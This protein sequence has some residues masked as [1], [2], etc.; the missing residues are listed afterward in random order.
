MNVEEFPWW[1]KEQRQ[2]A[3]EVEEFSREVAP[4]VEEADWRAKLGILDGSLPWDPIPQELKKRMVEKGYFGAMIPKEYGG[5]GLGVTGSCI[6]AEGLGPA[7]GS[8]VSTAIGGTHQIIR[9]GTK[10]QKERWLPKIASGEIGGAI[11]LTEPFVGSDAAGVET[12]AVREGDEY[13]VNG[14]KRFVTNLGYADLYIVYVKTSE[15]PE[16]KAAYGHMTALIV[17]KGTPGFTVEKVNMLCTLDPPQ[18]NGYLNFDD[19]RVPVA[20]RIGEENDAFLG[21]MVDGLNFERLMICA[22]TL[23]FMRISLKYAV[24]ATERRIQFG[25][26]TIDFESNQ[27]RIADMIT[28]LKLARLMTYYSAYL[29]DLG[30]EPI[31]EA[32]L[33]K[34]F[35][36]E[37]N[38]KAALDAMQCMG[39]DGLTKMYPVESIM[40]NMLMNV[41]GA[42]SSDIMKRLLV[43][44]A[45]RY[46]VGLMLEDLKLPRRRLHPEL[47]VP[48]SDWRGELKPK[49]TAKDP[50]GKVLEAL[51]LDYKVN[52][53]LYM[54]REDL[55]EDTDL[56]GEELNK[57]LMSLEEKGL[58]KLFR[59]HGVIR[60]A[61][62]L[63]TG[64]KKVKPQKFYNWYPPWVKEKLFP[65]PQ[66]TP[67]FETK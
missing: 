12:F 24:Y 46:Q 11:G 33:I 43:R 13:V 31:I 59:L 4:L 34:I 20:N 30:Q 10:E 14:K 42:G 50:E 36:T 37:T 65:A 61:K 51:A 27:Y 5:M 56:K 1:T 25:K 38:S 28:N 29:A 32:T 63:Y 3:R 8:F 53:G 64:L 40:R 23:G 17:E 18:L 41:I 49:L 6:I 44:Q 62:A 66:M 54:T 58:V 2:L 47:G 16:D 35:A 57:V 55:E 67:M 52:P 60:L 7:Y 15:K 21:V 26:R 48:V 22:L 45:T 9:H 39:G 19:V